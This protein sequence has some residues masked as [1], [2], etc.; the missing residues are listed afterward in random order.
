MNALQCYVIRTLPLLLI[1]ASSYVE[2]SRAFP[3][4]CILPSVSPDSCR[5]IKIIAYRRRQNITFKCW[6]VM[7]H[8]KCIEFQRV[9]FLKLSKVWSRRNLNYVETKESS[10]PELHT[11]KYRKRQCCWTCFSRMDPRWHSYGLSARGFGPWSL[12]PPTQV[13]THC[14]GRWVC[15]SRYGYD[16]WGGNNSLIWF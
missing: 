12:S 14:N 7:H 6:S 2:S 13:C 11:I 8:C 4:L 9:S 10:R 15:H 3:E 1:F 5:C 16:V